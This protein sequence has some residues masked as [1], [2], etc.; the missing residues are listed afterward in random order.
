MLLAGDKG[1]VGQPGRR[2]VLATRRGSPVDRRQAAGD[3]RAFGIAIDPAIL[4]CPALPLRGPRRGDI[5]QDGA[6]CATPRRRRGWLALNIP[7]NPQA[8]L[9][10]D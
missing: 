3:W 1:P 10:S 5:G 4:N 6:F 7:G 2:P 9:W 8:R